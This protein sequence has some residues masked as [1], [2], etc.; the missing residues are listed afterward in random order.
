MA[1]KVEHSYEITF[2]IKILS[3]MSR[4]PSLPIYLL[5]KRTELLDF[6]QYTLIKFSIKAEGGGCFAR[7]WTGASQ[8]PTPS[9]S[10]MIRVR[11]I[12]SVASFRSDPSVLC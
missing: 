1:E 10:L 2:R 8:L 7:K 12:C 3:I 5:V 6:A 11:Q 9:H 4:T